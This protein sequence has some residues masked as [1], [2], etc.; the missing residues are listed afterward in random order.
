MIVGALLA[1]AVALSGGA[2]K[3]IDLVTVNLTKD[4]DVPA[5]VAWKKIGGFCQIDQW[6]KADCSYTSG[7]G[8]L[9]TIRKVGLKGGNQTI[10]EAMVAQTPLSY[11][12]TMLIPHTP[13]YHGTMSVEATGKGKSKV[14]Y[15][16][17][18][19]QEPLTAEQRQ[20]TMDRMKQIFGGAMDN[21]KKVAE[22][23]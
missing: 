1:F 11:T 22:A 15:A 13:F 9:G 8:S 23:K 6:M 20:Q 2:A 7:T 4:L 10:D 21:M 16:M 17:V 14:I 18:W 19:D 12:Y 3:A 5:D